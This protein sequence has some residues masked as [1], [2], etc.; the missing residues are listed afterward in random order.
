MES[1][2]QP[3]AAELKERDPIQQ[4]QGVPQTPKVLAT[5]ELIQQDI[6]SF[7]FAREKLTRKFEAKRRIGVLKKALLDNSG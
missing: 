4:A 2:N 7:R 3:P 6:D 1:I 5:P